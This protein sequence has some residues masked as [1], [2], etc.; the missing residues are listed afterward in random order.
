[1]AVIRWMSSHQ[2]ARELGISVRT[3]RRWRE[4]GRL[5][6]GEHYRRKGPSP[7]SDVIYNVAACVQIIDDFTRDRAM[8]LGHV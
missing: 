8:E 5:K 1:M 2:T 4:S 7:D 6:P 3:L